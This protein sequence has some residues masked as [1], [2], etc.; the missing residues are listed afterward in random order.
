[1]PADGQHAGQ[2]LHRRLA[3][4]QAQPLAQFDRP[5]GDAVEQRRGAR[6][7]ARPAA[8]INRGPSAGAARQPFPQRRYLG[9]RRAGK[10]HPQRVEQHDP[11]VAAHRLRDAVVP[12]LGDNAGEGFDLLPQSAAC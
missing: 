3:G 8:R 4:D 10:D 1:L 12:R 2:Y 11:G 6:V 5:P 9:P 7:L